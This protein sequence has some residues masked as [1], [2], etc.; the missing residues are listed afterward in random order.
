MRRACQGVSFALFLLLLL[1][2]AWPYAQRFGT[3]VLAD[4]EWVQ[5][6]AFLWLDPLASVAAAVAGRCVGPF[7]I[8]AAAILWVSLLVPRVFC[9]YICPL[10]TTIDLADW[11]LGRRLKRLHVRRRG[12][13]VHIKYYV[14]AAV[15]AAAALGVML[16]GYVAAIP[17]ATRGFVFALGPAQLAT[18]KHASMVRPV[19]W[20]YWLAIALFLCIPALTVLGRRFWCRNLCP[21]GALFS[22]LSPLRLRER[23]VNDSCIG[24]GKCVRACTFDAI[25]PDFSTRVAECA[26][27]PDCARACPVSAIEFR[28]PSFEFRGWRR[29]P[30]SDGPRLSRRALLCASAAGA[31]AA[32]GIAL[33][34]HKRLL[35]P[36]GSLREERFLEL[37]VRCGLCIKVCPGPVL[38]P[39]GLGAGLDALWTPVAVP[40]WAGCH[41]ECNFC[42]QV[43]PTG[44]I[45]P[46]P[47]EEKK[48]THMGLAV[49]NTRTCLPH[50]GKRD[51]QLC[52]DECRA[53]GYNAIEMRPIRIEVGEVP[54]GVLTAAETE[55][56][57]RILAPFVKPEAC[58]GC[59]LCEYRCGTKWAKQERL[60]DTSAIIVVPENE[61]RPA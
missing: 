25:R 26:F 58:V 39:A 40:S 17:L 59:G 46:L 9:S 51:C 61:D 34:R 29:V 49:V 13:W 56:A 38:H 14:L 23:R 50:A 11:A 24:C 33:G 4:K 53:A 16:A 48:K 45:R 54:E 36:P 10:G 1:Y 30:S 43:C 12:G 19:G 21:T 41:Q 32:T 37:C 8:G 52:R 7:L 27:C 6:E 44:A 15:L 5:A 3:R 57:G 20:N 2:V 28:V 42:G 35:R 31:W 47:I 22:L 55:E 18:L 60:L